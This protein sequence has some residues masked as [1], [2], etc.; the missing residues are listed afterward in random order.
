MRWL[1]I[2]LV[3]CGAHAN[4]PTTGGFRVF[5]P[6]AEAPLKV[7]ARMQIK[8]AADCHYDD[9]RDGKWANTGAKVVAGELPPGLALEDGAIAGAPTQVGTW[10]VT[11]GFTGVTCAGQ[12]QP[13]Q[14]VDVDLVVR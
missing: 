14:R 2:A 11:I 6:S 5:Y 12:T 1:A 7:R 8:P 10:H 3:A 13:D 4:A 9:G